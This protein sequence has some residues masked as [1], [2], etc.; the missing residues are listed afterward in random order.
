MTLRGR[1]SPGIAAVALVATVLLVLVG[2]SGESS[3]DRP[4][5]LSGGSQRVEV[6]GCRE[7]VE[8]GKITPNRKRDTIIGPMAFIGLP[9]T[10][11]SWA[12]RPDSELVSVPGLG[13]PSMKAI[14]VLRAGARV[15]LVVPPRQRR[16][17]KV[18]YDFP[19][20]RGG[21]AIALEACRRLGS[22]PARRR[23]CGW[24]PDIACRWRYT[25]FSGG[26]GLDF[27]RAPRRGRCAK[28]IVRIAG[29]EKALSRRLFQP[30]LGACAGVR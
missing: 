13:M 17:M 18:I 4:D 19:R 10:Y 11:R 21:Q 3:G 2:Q 5:A 15:T 6:R 30:K 27:A 28:L 14:G 26:F 7:R 29:R 23:E 1:S 25:Q 20:H 9:A 12:R 22:A 8:G 24:R 16:W